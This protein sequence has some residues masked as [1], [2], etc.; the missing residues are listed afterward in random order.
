MENQVGSKRS[1]LRLV[2][3]DF[4]S[5]YAC[6]TTHSGIQAS[7]LGQARGEHWPLGDAETHCCAL[8]NISLGSAQAAR[9][10]GSVCRR[11]N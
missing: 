1:V 5:M 6:G 10:L 8:R 2:L 3:H 4:D 7:A 9:F 11:R